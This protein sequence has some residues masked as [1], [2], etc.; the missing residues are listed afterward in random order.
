M[1]WFYFLGLH[2]VNKTAESS[3]YQKI[4]FQQTL[5]F[6]NAYK[7]SEH[8]LISLFE[9]ACRRCDVLSSGYNFLFSHNM[10]L[11]KG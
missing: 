4:I 8:T 1:L 5:S 2:F 9:K 11:K 3:G 6:K 10:S 7:N